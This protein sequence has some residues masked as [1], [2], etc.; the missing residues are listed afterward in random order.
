MAGPVGLY[1][2]GHFI[3]APWLGY[4]LVVVAGLIGFAFRDSAFNQIIK[5]YKAEKYATL[6]A[7]K[8]K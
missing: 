3:V 2:L 8:Q 5:I 6:A 4:V 7:Y 1:A